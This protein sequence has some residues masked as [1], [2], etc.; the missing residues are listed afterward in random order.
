MPSP[1]PT[2]Y[3]RFVYSKPPDLADAVRKLERRVGKTREDEPASLEERLHTVEELLID[4]LVRLT[5][6]P[7]RVSKGA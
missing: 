5:L 3:D 7:G 2:E 1:F 4:A 6:P